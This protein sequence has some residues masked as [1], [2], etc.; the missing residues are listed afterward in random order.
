MSS[1]FVFLIGIKVV[2]KR[3]KVTLQHLIYS[4]LI[5]KS[6]TFQLFCLTIH[7]RSFF[8]IFVNEAI[9]HGKPYPHYI[10][11]NFDYNNIYIKN[12]QPAQQCCR[13]FENI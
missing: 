5:C 3:F 7:L 6:S 1:V 13:L 2:S 4:F 8:S 12:S 11:V 10:I 9:S